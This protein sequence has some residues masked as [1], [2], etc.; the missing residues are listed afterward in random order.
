MSRELPVELPVEEWPARET[1][2]AAGLLQELYDHFGIKGRRTELPITVRWAEDRPDY[3]G[4]FDEE[5]GNVY[6]N[7]CLREHPRVELVRLMAEEVAHFKQWQEDHWFSEPHAKMEAARFVR[8]YET[9]AAAAQ[10]HAADLAAK[11]A[12]AARPIIRPR[13]PGSSFEPVYD[14]H[15]HLRLEAPKEIRPI[16]PYERVVELKYASISP[17]SRTGATAGEELYSRI[18]HF[19]RDLRDTLQRVNGGAP[20]WQGEASY[21]RAAALYGD[22]LGRE[23]GSPLSAPY[24]PETAIATFVTDVWGRWTE[25]QNLEGQLGDLLPLMRAARGAFGAPSSEELL[26]MMPPAPIQPARGETT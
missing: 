6:V 3:G 7:I 4:M 5:T 1:C 25:L 16:Y 10:A 17:S 15:A 24:T 2:F 23:A 8:H 12:A 9:K 26:P 14:R 21:A 18:E 11:A 22:A 13:F 19:A 20:T